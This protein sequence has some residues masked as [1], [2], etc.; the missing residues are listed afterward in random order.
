V[1]LDEAL[2]NMAVD[3][4]GDDGD[5]ESQYRYVL[6]LYFGHGVSRNFAKATKYFKMSADQRRADHE[7]RKTSVPDG[8]NNK[9]DRI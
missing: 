5:E 3:V 8:K 6:C 1:D 7:K 2:E 9:N 4:L